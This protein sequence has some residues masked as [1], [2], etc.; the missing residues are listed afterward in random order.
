[1]M[2]AHE[3]HRCLTCGKVT[4]H[5]RPTFPF[6]LGVLPTAVTAGVFL[7][8]WPFV[9]LHYS[10]QPW[11]CTVCGSKWEKLAPTKANTKPPPPSTWQQG[12]GGRW[13]SR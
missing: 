8:I 9:A 12:A 13:R 10:M 7:F 1:M 11:R 4:K 2:E 5:E 3:A 6:W